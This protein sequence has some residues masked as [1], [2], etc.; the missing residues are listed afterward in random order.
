MYTT[1]AIIDS[2]TGRDARIYTPM[3]FKKFREE[4]RFQIAFE[5]TQ[6]SH[7]IKVHRNDSC[8]ENSETPI[9]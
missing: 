5:R 8:Y 3:L 4:G 2:R 1:Q 9:L 6:I 7:M